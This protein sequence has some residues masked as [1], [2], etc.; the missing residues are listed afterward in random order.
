MNID[1]YRP[2]ISALRDFGIGVATEH[3]TILK[4]GLL[5]LF[6][7]DW[8]TRRRHSNHLNPFLHHSVKSKRGRRMATSPFFP[9]SSPYVQCKRFYCP[10]CISLSCL[11]ATGLEILIRLESFVQRNS[12]RELVKPIQCFASDPFFKPI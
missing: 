12:K 11:L 4:A 3:L 9:I 10:H 2:P 1:L 7:D 5:D 8:P 6:L